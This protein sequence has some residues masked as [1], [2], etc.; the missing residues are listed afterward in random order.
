MGCQ[1]IYLRIFGDRFAQYGQVAEVTPVK[2]KTGISTG[3]IIVQV[4]LTRESFNGIPDILTC[5]GRR[6]F[7]VVQGRRLHC[8]S[9]VA[10]GYM[11]KECLGKNPVPPIQQRTAKQA[12][13]QQQIAV[14]KQ[15]VSPKD[16]N[17]WQ[18]V[19]RRGHESRASSYPV[20]AKT[21]EP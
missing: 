11:A 17:E 1:W 20:R 15:C 12:A 16:A 3:D 13:V 14:R 9:C 19:I 21:R 5:G 2:G 8:W 10:A 6:T 4:T 18:H 7:A